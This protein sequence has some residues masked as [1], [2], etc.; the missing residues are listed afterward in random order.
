MGAHVYHTTEKEDSFCA[1]VSQ[2]GMRFSANK[3]LDNNER[4]C[5]DADWKQEESIIN[6]SKNAFCAD[7]N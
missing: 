3:H 6:H 7:L 4:P 1:S 2:R 5:K